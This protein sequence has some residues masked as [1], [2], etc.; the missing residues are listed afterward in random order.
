M[1]LNIGKIILLSLYSSLPNA[2]VLNGGG[3]FSLDTTKREIDDEKLMISEVINDK[4]T[5]RASLRT[6]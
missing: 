3:N 1:Y 2:K 6:Y 5:C 4:V